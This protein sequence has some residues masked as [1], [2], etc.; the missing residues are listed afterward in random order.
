[1]ITKDYVTPSTGATATVHVV[2]QVSLDYTGNTTTYVTVASYVSADA[3]AA[4]KLPVFTQQIQL[5]GLPASGQDARDYAEARLVEP[6]PA[7]GP[8]AVNRY[9]FSGG[10]L[11]S[12]APATETTT[13]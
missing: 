9:V 8:Y 6:V 2:N 11:D 12:A 4:G 5:E 3:H 7:T 10:V 13:S 1:M